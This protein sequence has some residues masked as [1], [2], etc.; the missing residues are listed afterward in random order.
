MYTTVRIGKTVTSKD[1]IVCAIFALLIYMSLTLVLQPNLFI[2]ML[3]G[4]LIWMN[5]KTFDIY[6]IKRRDQIL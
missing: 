5:I 4:Y 6:C 2:N 3:G 1:H